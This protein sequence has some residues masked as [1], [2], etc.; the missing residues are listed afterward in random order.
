MV[1][2]ETAVQHKQLLGCSNRQPSEFV[3][4]TLKIAG[5]LFSIQC[6][7]LQVS[8]HF[9]KALYMSKLTIRMVSL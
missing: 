6:E 2:D 3:A 9:F 4:T 7:N 5:D 8:K 1:R